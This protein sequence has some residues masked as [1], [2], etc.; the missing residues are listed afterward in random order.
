MSEGLLRADMDLLQ[1]RMK[2]AHRR[3]TDAQW[4]LKLENQRTSENIKWIIS[5]SRQ[6]QAYQERLRDT[7]EASRAKTE[8]LQLVYKNIEL[9]GQIIMIREGL[10]RAMELTH[11]AEKT[12]EKVSKELERMSEERLEVGF[13]DKRTRNKQFGIHKSA[14]GGGKVSLPA[15]KQTR[16]YNEFVILKTKTDEVNTRLEMADLK[17][18]GLEMRKLDLILE[19]ENYKAMKNDVI[20]AKIIKE[21]L[22]GANLKL[23]CVELGAI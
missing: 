18:A 13:E 3:Y 14:C 11:R 16:K 15:T 12:V 22:Q 2:E 4:R 5:Y 1:H 6:I 8:K 7:N 17:I 20:K 21:N 23:Y 10:K 19:I 9:H